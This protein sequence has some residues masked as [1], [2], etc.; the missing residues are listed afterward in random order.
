MSG[1]LHPIPG[2]VLLNSTGTGTIGRSCVFAETGREFIVDTHVTAIRPRSDIIDGRWLNALLSSPWGQS[3]L[4]AHCYTGST[5]QIELSGKKLATSIVPV[6][7]LDEQRKIAEVLDAIDERIDAVR[8][9]FK[10]R[11]R[12]RAGLLRDVLQTL[13]TAKPSSG[14]LRLP[15]AEVVPSVD[16]GISHAITEE[17]TELPVLRMNNVG[18]GKTGFGE[19]KYFPQ[20]VPP[21]LLLKYGDVL[22]NRTNSIEHVGRSGMWRNELPKA[23][24]A[25][26]LVRLNV[27]PTRLIP[28]YLALW[29]SHPITRQRVR[30]ISTP[31]V[32]QVNVNPTNLRAL[33]IDLPSSLDEQR[34]ITSLLDIA[35]SQI[36]REQA[37]LDKLRLLK[38]GLLA[39]LLT[40]KVRVT[41]GGELTG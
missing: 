15:L 17:P 39:D 30:A 5:N 9:V 1:T 29:L 38:K 8:R 4:E 18:E 36:V 28:D 14:W 6:P 31:A 26:Y 24:F 7:G 35:D 22:F 19:L 34:R 23:T 27:N 2:D 21:G 3:H 33:P 20:T 11:K 40:G 10:K 41:P 12:I 13:S 16:Y 25:S 32:Q 37:E